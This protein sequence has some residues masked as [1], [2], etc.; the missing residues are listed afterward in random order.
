VL[1]FKKC[2]E[3]QQNTSQTQLTAI[4]LKPLV[5]RMRTAAMATGANGNGRQA[6][7]Q[8]YVGVS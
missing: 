5:F 8:G 1:L 4:R 2:E 7:R 3:Q 6:E